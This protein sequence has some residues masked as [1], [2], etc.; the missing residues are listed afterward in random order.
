MSFS[1]PSPMWM[2]HRSRVSWR[3]ATGRQALAFFPCFEEV[4]ACHN[5]GLRWKKTKLLC[6]LRQEVVC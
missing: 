1:L 6:T 2:S 3:S 5:H 4:D